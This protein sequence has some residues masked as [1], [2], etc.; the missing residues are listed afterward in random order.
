MDVPETIVNINKAV[1]MKKKFFYFFALIG[2]LLGV[3][4]GIGYTLYERAWV[5]AA[6]V[7]I[8]S[9]LAFPKAKEYLLKLINE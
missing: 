9:A 1:D 7:V 3:I 6:G 2:Y 5:I 4:G 8:L